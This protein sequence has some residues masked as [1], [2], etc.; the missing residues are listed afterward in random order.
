MQLRSYCV[1]TAGL[2]LQMQP[3][4]STQHA[5]SVCFL[6]PG[7]YMLY[8]YD[9]HQLPDPTMLLQQGNSEM[10]H[11]KDPVGVVAVSP[12]YFLVE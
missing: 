8:A 11:T 12:M 1:L 5:F 3:H 4:S 2:Q 6:A 7:V 9:I 10:G